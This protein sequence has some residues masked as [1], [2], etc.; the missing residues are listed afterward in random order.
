MRPD[1]FWPLLSIHSNN[2]AS[3]KQTFADIGSSLGKT[4]L[5]AHCRHHQILQYSYLHLIPKVVSSIN[6]PISACS[7]HHA[8]KP[9][10]CVDS[11]PR[12]AESRHRIRSCHLRRDR[13]QPGVV[14]RYAPKTRIR[15]GRAD[16]RTVGRCHDV[17]AQEPV[18]TTLAVVS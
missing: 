11:D 10:L 14:G 13:L 1:R 2:R 5:C 15:P 4:S 9:H 12:A 6:H 3:A 17:P 7:G 16:F 8:S 18:R